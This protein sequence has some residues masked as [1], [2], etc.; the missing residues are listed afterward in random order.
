M[1]L[2]AD[3]MHRFILETQSEDFKNAHPV[4]QA[5]YAHYA[6]VA[7][8]PFA[9]GNGRVAR[10]LASVFTLRAESIP[11]LVSFD[12][13]D[14]YYAALQEADQKGYQSFVDFMF[15]RSL[16]GIQLA[17]ESFE[18]AS[19]DDFISS[20]NEIGD[21][22][23]T[24]SG[25]SYDDIEKA[26][27]SLIIYFRNTVNQEL[28]S[29]SL[30]NLGFEISQASSSGGN[31]DYKI[32]KSSENSFNIRIWSNEPK[33]ADVYRIFS[34]FIPSNANYDDLILIRDVQNSDEKY[35]FRVD[36]VLPEMK[37]E[38]QI[39]TSIMVKRLLGRMFSDLK[40]KIHETY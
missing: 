33:F 6:F 29:I 19:V 22:F 23:L 39:R 35:E 21:L 11:I 5:A 4:L 27:V 15:D 10:A 34:V 20:A 36:E 16:S 17:I 26:A 37:S 31:E 32:P 38:T 3:E 40:R 1:D 12:T 18:A 25:Y 9:D 13:R 28:R 30:Q 2:T 24:K 8:H 7:I 14:E